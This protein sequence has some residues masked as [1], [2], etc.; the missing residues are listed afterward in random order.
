MNWEARA[1]CV[2]SASGSSLRQIGKD[3]LDCW[4]YQ[5]MLADVETFSQGRVSI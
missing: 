4:V 5:A 3:F 2:A 1:V